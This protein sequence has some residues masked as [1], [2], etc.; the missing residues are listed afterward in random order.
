MPQR[1]ELL[2]SLQAS[3]SYDIEF[4]FESLT[5]PTYLLKEILLQPVNHLPSLSGSP[6]YRNLVVKNGPQEIDGDGEEAE[7]CHESCQRESR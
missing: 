6:T 4:S 1:S 3:T 5:L 2:T 7:C